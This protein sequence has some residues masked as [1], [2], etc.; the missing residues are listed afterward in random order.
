MTD[1]D[2]SLV[3]LEADESRA[4]ADLQ[5]A[6]DQMHG[7]TLPEKLAD[8]EQKEALRML[9]LRWLRTQRAILTATTERLDRTAQGNGH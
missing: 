8:P 4:L 9:T 5:R 7:Q 1:D 3:E 2:K 6:V